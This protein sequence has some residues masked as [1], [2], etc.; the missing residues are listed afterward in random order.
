MVCL[1]DPEL[2]L[3]MTACKP[4]PVEERDCFLRC[5][6]SWE[7]SRTL[8]RHPGN[9]GKA[10][11]GASRLRLTARNW[12]CRTRGGFTPFRRADN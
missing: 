9:A 10:L 6:P 12:R 2:E 1:T 4:L 5:S 3:V 8:S 7:A 11:Q